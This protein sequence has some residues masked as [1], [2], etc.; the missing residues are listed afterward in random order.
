MT[1]KIAIIL[2]KSKKIVILLVI[3]KDNELFWIKFLYW[4]WK[5]NPNNS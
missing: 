3:H 1:C 2:M 5:T 4:P